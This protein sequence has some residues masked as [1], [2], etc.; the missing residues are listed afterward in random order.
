MRQVF[1]R[2][3]KKGEIL[4]WVIGIIILAVAVSA[5]VFLFSSKSFLGNGDAQGDA[6]SEENGGED[7]AVANDIGDEGDIG[8]GVAA[9]DIGDE[10]D[11]GAGVAQ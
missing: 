5:Y 3:E 6:S 7:N 10:G 11:I 2:R 4:W 8:A 1:N 9:D